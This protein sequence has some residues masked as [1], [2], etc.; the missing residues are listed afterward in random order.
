VPIGTTQKVGVELLVN[1][2]PVDTIDNADG[3]LKYYS[4]VFVTAVSMD[5]VA[6]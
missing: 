3:K 1:G 6:H 2:E 5:S 4:I